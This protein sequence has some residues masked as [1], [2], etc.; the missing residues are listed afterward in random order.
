MMI[1]TASARPRRPAAVAL[2]FA[3]T[4]AAVL[5]GCASGPSIFVNEDP[6]ATFGAYR[7]YGFAEPLGTDRPEYSSLLS[8]YLKTAAARELESRGYRFS[9]EPELLVNFYLETKE[10]IRS[11]STPSGGPWIGGYYGYRRGH[12]GVWTGYETTV[13]QYT[14]GTL[15]VDVVDRERKQLVWEA[16]VVGRIRDADREDVQGTVDSV[17]AQVFSRFPYRAPGTPAPVEMP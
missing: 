17:L 6:A 3:L 8:Q 10:K 7:T 13:S 5:A 2:V 9:E 12:Y 1:L 4:C 15:N 14:E 16:T 11:T